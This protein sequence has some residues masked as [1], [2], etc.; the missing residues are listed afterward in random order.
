MRELEGTKQG[1]AG[2][3]E[4]VIHSFIGPF[5]GSVIHLTQAIQQ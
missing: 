5:V 1:R 2:A 3:K 4:G